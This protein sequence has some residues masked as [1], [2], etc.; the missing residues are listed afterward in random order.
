MLPS[1]YGKAN[2]K[3]PSRNYFL[4]AGSQDMKGIIRVGTY[5]RQLLCYDN[6]MLKC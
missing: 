6:L 5:E 1:I 3:T 4:N 2:N